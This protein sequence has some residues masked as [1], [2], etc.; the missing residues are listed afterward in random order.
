MRISLRTMRDFGA[1]RRRLSGADAALGFALAIFTSGEA[2][3]Q[4]A[5]PKAPPTLQETGLYADFAALKVDPGHLAFSPQ[6]PLWTDGA[7]KR[8]WISLPPGT[9]IDA[10]DPDAWVFPVG[11]RLWKEFSF[12]GQRV[13]TR[14]LERKADG[15]LYAAYAWSPDGTEAQLV[16]ERGQR[17]AYPLGGGRSH[18]I[19]GVTDCKACHQGGRSE[20]LGFSALQLSPDR[21]PAAPHAEPLPFPAVDL[22]YLVEKGLL[23]GLPRSVRETPPRIAAASATERAALGYLHGNC[24]HCHNPQG[25]LQNVGL[26]LRHATGASVPPAVASTV[27]HPVKKPAPGQSPDAVLRVEPGH[28][29]RSALMQR[30]SSRYPA[31]QMPPL[32]TALVDEEALALVERWI[33]EAE[34]IRKEAN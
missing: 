5:P 32:G 20:V 18:T 13:E 8:R 7:A 34:Q 21:D 25:P 2:A 3:P 31:L 1:G 19:P 24:G 29:E 30:I 11:T 15:W 17:G 16:S 23:V 9:A 6:Y 28:P 12:G 14:Y 26:F 22:N 10:S 4:P 33:R 27:R